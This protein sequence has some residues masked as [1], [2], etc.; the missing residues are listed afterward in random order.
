MLATGLWAA[1]PAAGVVPAARGVTAPGRVA[2]LSL[3]A[4][5]GKLPTQANGYVPK[6]ILRSTGPPWEAYRAANITWFPTR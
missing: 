5:Q 2:P 3:R 4:S 1:V 6:G